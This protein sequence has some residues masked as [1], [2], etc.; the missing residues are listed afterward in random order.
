MRQQ[1]NYSA[2]LH[3][4][5]ELL[6]IAN[7]TGARQYTRD[8]HDM[9][10]KLF[11]VQQKNDSAYHHLR[12]YTALKETIDA[13]QAEQKLAFFRSEIETE[14]ARAGMDRLTKEK[15]LQELQ[16]YALIVFIVFLLGMGLIIFRNILLKRKSERHQREIGRK[17]IKDADI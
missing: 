2:A 7:E 14:K 13:D 10:F 5:R 3:N 16:K 15:Q 4:A 17:R 9:L 12:Q 6:R 8:A 1:K 11:D